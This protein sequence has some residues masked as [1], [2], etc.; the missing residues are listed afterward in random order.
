M[1][2][3]A[4]AGRRFREGKKKRDKEVPRGMIPVFYFE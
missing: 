2:P 4:I 1:H 3:V